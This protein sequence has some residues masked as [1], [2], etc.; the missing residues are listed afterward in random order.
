MNV[1]PALALLTQLS[2]WVLASADACAGC[3]QGCRRVHRIHLNLSM[4][5]CRSRQPEGHAVAC[6]AAVRRRSSERHRWIRGSAIVTALARA[7]SALGG[8]SV[9]G[10][11]R[12]AGTAVARAPGGDPGP[13]VVRGPFAP[14]LSCAAATR[15][16]GSG[17]ARS[18]VRNRV[19]PLLTCTRRSQSTARA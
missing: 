9:N 12:V 7:R 5:A 6:R 2:A 1:E 8:G 4:E 19:R 18:S 17:K 16:R 13:Q 3:R 11:A 15:G 10:R 14:G